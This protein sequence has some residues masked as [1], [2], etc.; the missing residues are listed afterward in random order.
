MLGD[1]RHFTT[2]NPLANILA[3]AQQC[4]AQITA[5]L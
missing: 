1:N 5:I 2:K 3:D 4:Q